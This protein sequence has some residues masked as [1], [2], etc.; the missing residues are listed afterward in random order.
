MKIEKMIIKI[1]LKLFKKRV[2]ICQKIKPEK[3][4]ARALFLMALLI[5]ERDI[6]AGCP[7]YNIDGIVNKN[8]KI[9]Y[10]HAMPTIPNWAPTKKPAMR[11]AELITPHFSHRS[12]RPSD[13]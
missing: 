4:D 9:E 7:A 2:F 3:A 6:E 12:E 1:A 13:T 10:A 11:I 5:S 8:I